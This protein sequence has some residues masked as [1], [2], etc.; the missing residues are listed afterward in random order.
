MDAS[1]QVLWVLFCFVFLGGL[2]SQILF[3]ADSAWRDPA[4]SV[5][6][7]PKLLGTA[8]HLVDL[9]S[10]GAG[11]CGE[12][13][14]FQVECP[15]GDRRGQGSHVGAHAHSGHAPARGPSPTA[16]ALR[17]PRLSEG[18]H[19]VTVGCM[20]QLSPP[21]GNKKESLASMPPLPVCPGQHPHPHPCFLLSEHLQ[22]AQNCSGFTSLCFFSPSK[23]F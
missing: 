6:T 9:H 18:S 15:E 16:T 8:A 10:C 13:G 17:P 21:A 5:R 20:Y 19:R 11:V 2:L 3:R 7:L 1:W 23:S 22:L 14:P 4:P 12:V